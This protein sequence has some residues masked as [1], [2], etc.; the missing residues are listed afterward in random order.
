MSAV[1]FIW[2]RDVAPDGAGRTRRCSLLCEYRLPLRWN[3][4][5]PF[6]SNYK[7]VYQEIREEGIFSYVYVSEFLHQIEK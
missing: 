6:L 7:G 5:P 1:G 4:Q 3:F 2:L